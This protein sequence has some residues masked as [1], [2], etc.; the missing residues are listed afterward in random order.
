M[1][2]GR[3]TPEL[4][5][6]G[7][8]LLSETIDM[9]PRRRTVRVLV[10]LLGVVALTPA[11]AG[12]QT[13]TTA[14]RALASSFE[15]GLSGWRADGARLRLVSRGPQG[16]AALVTAQKRRPT[17]FSVY[18]SRP[19]TTG[20][21]GT[22][23]TAAAAVRGTGRGFGLCLGVTE[24][25]GATIVGA[26]KRCARSTGRWQRLGD[27]VYQT[28]SAGGSL[29][30]SIS[31]PLSLRGAQFR[32]DDVQLVP[33]ASRPSPD[34]RNVL[35][36][37]R[38]RHIRHRL[39]HLR[40]LHLHLRHLH[41]HLRHL[42]RHPSA[43]ASAASA[44]TSPATSAATARQRAGPAVGAQFHC[45]WAV[46]NNA[47]R[48][49]VLNRLQAAGV[50]LGSHRHGLERHRGRV[51]GRA[52]HLAHRHGRL[53]RERGASA[54]HEGAADAVAHASLG[55]RRPVRQGSPDQPS[56]LTPTSPAGPPST[57]AAGSTP[58]K[59]GTSLTSRTSSPARRRNTSSS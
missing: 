1:Y 39:R 54:R 37:L 10:C 36:S 44:T 13:P 51:Q 49:A 28:K 18:R 55:Q 32:V 34:K 24:S 46:Y 20:A 11:A 7:A 17:T 3:G 14:P 48:I 4:A 45:N 25:V 16:R 52:E 57:G 21:A 59:S 50:T 56:G 35:R 58:G 5:M 27:L 40:H 15:Q 26:A 41:L 22:F 31:K 53:L 47:D 43:T 2:L 33:S 8:A 19:L 23:Y 12:A 30:L 9:E 29:A 6:A 38:R 42:L